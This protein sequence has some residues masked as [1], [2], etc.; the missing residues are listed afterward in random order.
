MAELAVSQLFPHLAHDGMPGRI[1]TAG[2]TVGGLREWRTCSAAAG[3]VALPCR[4]ARE[5]TLAM[6]TGGIMDAAVDLVPVRW[7]KRIRT[8]G[9]GDHTRHPSA[10]RI[11]A[12]VAAPDTEYC[13][14]PLL[15]WRAGRRITVVYR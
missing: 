7:H 13:Q 1:N 11:E 12:R 15:S 2:A 8:A 10:V 3:P 4:D 6:T 9:S 5:E 14:W